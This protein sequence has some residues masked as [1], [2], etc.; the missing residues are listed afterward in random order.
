MT[1]ERMRTLTA[2]AL[3]AT[4]AMLT[5][6]A[7]PAAADG[8]SGSFCYEGS[9]TTRTGS[10]DM[11]AGYPTH[12][13]YRASVTYRLLYTCSGTNIG[14]HVISSTASYTGGFNGTGDYNSKHGMVQ[15]GLS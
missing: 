10:L 2:A 9:T 5:F 13:V 4:L 3:A 14:V 15:T 8:T 1:L 6:S 12:V 7:Q 11:Q